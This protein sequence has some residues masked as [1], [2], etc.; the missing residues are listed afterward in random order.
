[1]SPVLIPCPTINEYLRILTSESFL[2][3]PLSLDD[4]VRVFT[5]NNGFSYLVHVSAVGFPEPTVLS[6]SCIGSI[7]SPRHGNLTSNADADFAVMCYSPR[8]RGAS[9]FLSPDKELF[10]GFVCQHTVR[11]LSFARHG[12]KSDAFDIERKRSRKSEYG[13]PNGASHTLYTPNC[14]YV[15]VNASYI[16]KLQNWHRRL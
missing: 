1:M 12:T 11:F 2:P 14:A 10:S 8:K 13:N 16:T 7:R 3:V 15:H 6:S 5:K 4:S 9:T